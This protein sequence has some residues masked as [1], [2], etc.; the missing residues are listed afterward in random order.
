VTLALLTVGLGVV[1]GFCLQRG[2]FCGST[3]LSS[4][5]LERDARGLV[6]I[7]FAVA[8]SMTGFAGLAALDLVVPDPNPLRLLSAVAGGLVFG[9]GMVLAG[10]CVSGTLFK[11]AEGRLPSMLALVGIGLGMVAT[12][13]G[14]LSPA[15]RAL[16]E[17]TRGVRAP[18][19]LGALVGVPYPLA[20]GAVGTLALAAML[21]LHARQCRRA[22]R[23]VLP[24]GGQLL[25]GA[26]TPAVAGVAVG[27]IGWLAYLVSTASGRNYPLGVMGGVQAAFSL[28]VRGETDVGTWSLFL[29]AGIL[30]GSA[31]SALLRRDWRLRSAEPDTLL[32]ALAGGLLVG[33]GVS[34]GR[35]CFVGNMVSGLGLLSLHSLI[36]AAC[37]VAANWITTLLYLRGLR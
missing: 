6:G 12:E 11:A 26:W 16:V 2:A 33:F 18:S 34:V 1:L 13:D 29:C 17:A 7:G 9:V 28:L 10:G 31:L 14:L 30:A 3:L 15:K 21:V 23:P 4:F 27:A 5:I 8:V 19:G 32:V 37:T 35:G 22:G 20:A 25:R 36:F 24:E